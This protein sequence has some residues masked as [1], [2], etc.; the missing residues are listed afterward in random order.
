MAFWRIAGDVHRG[1]AQRV[2]AAARQLR[3]QLSSLSRRRRGTGLLPGM[4]LTRPTIPL[5]CVNAFS[6]P[7]VGLSCL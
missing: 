7:H 2:L 6:E 1:T 5:Y 4:R 3:R